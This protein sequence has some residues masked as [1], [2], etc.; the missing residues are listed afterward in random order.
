MEARRF[1]PALARCGGYAARSQAALALVFQLA[2]PLQLWL[3][4]PPAMASESVSAKRSGPAVLPETTSVQSGT[5]ADVSPTPYSGSPFHINAQPTGTSAASG[6]G[7]FN[8]S[9]FPAALPI[10]S[11]VPT[12][13]P[14][15]LPGEQKPSLQPTPANVDIVDPALLARQALE[16]SYP[17]ELPLPNQL[18]SLSTKLPAIRLEASYNEPLNLRDVL[19]Y[20]VMNNLAIR[21]QRESMISQK[22]LWIG[23]LG[24]FMPNII[25]NYQDQLLSGASLIGGVIPAR[26]HTP[27]ASCQAGFQFFGF[28]GGSI[29]FNMLSNLHQ[30]KSQ[31]A[32]LG[33]TINNTL[34]SV[35]QGYY[36]LVLNQALLQIQIKAVDVSRAQLVLNRQ[37]EQAGTGTRFQ[38]L[39][40]ETQLASDEQN[41]LTQQVNFRQAA[42]NL[43]ALLNLNLGVNL[44]PRE[45]DVKKVR[46]ID[47]E[48]D[49]N[50]LINIAVLNRPELKQFNELRIAARRNIQVA[51]APLYP[52]FQFFGN[53]NGNGAT[54]T[55]QF[56]FVPGT[57]ETVVLNGPSPPGQIIF[58][59]NAPSG[60]TIFPAGEV[61]VPPGFIS[62]QMRKSY[63]I[64]VRVDWN[65]PACGIPSLAN[66][67]STR[68]LARQATLNL[69]Q[70][71]LNV[72]QAVRSSYLNS[73]T[74][75]RQIDVAS[76]AVV[77]SAEQ[78]RLSRVRLANGVGTNIDVLQAQSAW[79]QAL[80]NKANAIVLF[81]NAQVQLLHDIG[82]ITVD[83]LTSGRLV[84]R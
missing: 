39:Q 75:E 6:Q 53:V 20:A 27:N 21:I 22:W 80:V 65:Y 57:F 82:L 63:A 55:R 70:Q 13:P 11:Q 4:T 59:S 64:G 84:R 49:I 2:F 31:K 71:L 34:L 37:L 54:T 74:A 35:A 44:L 47:P 15:Y 40:A 28:Q 61:F 45:K 10:L 43:A 23:A 73:M 68:A 66:I 12:P 5:H 9:I 7:L 33:A 24:Q 19:N 14:V 52:K 41:L 58:P 69:N 60:G 32:G 17:L 25:M 51:A 83:T 50:D 38:V 67:Q 18:I 76:K 77:S 36:N 26:F 62:R 29:L 56:A 78:L 16:E 79:V 1:S 48:M 46:L 8:R 42:L 81:N 72:I 3:A 30:F